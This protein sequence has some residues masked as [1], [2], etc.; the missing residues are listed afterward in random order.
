MLRGN[1]KSYV[2]ENLQLMA[3]GLFKYIQP[4][5]TPDMKGLTTEFK[6]FKA[7]VMKQK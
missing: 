2:L 6:V 3:A 7:F 5:V 1:K 4:L